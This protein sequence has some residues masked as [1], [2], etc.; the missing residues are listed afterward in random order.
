MKYFT[1]VHAGLASYFAGQDIDAIMKDPVVCQAYLVRSATHLAGPGRASSPTSYGTSTYCEIHLMPASALTDAQRCCTVV[2]ERFDELSDHRYV[3]SEYAGI[4]LDR[5]GRR[6]AGWRF[7]SAPSWFVQGYEEYLALTLSNDHS[8]TITFDKY[9]DLLRKNP[10]RIGWLSV[11]NDYT[12][13]AVLVHFFHQE[14]GSAKIKAVLL[15]KE[16]TFHAALKTELGLTP[17]QLSTR[18]TAWRK[19]NL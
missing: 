3:A 17:E 5:L 15:S 2:G 16:K 18:W 10:E 4:L 1:D 9:K 13:G 14:F 6:N 11:T 12:D 19:K 8:R 7:H